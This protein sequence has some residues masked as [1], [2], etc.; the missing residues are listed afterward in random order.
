MSAMIRLS[1][2]RTVKF[3]AEATLEAVVDPDHWLYGS[4]VGIELL[5][6]SCW[7][8][9]VHH[10]ASVEDQAFRIHTDYLVEFELQHEVRVTTFEREVYAHTMGSFYTIPFFR[11][12]L[13]AGMTRLGLSPL[14]VAPRTIPELVS[15]LRAAQRSDRSHQSRQSKSH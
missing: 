8:Y 11:E 10:D 1:R 5:T 15:Q 7:R 6:A 12:A 3:T 4:W 13:H 2:I 9:R 14:M